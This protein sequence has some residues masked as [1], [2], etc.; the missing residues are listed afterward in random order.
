MVDFIGIG[1]QRTAT[2]WLYSCM[3]EH[4]EICAPEKEIHFFSRPRYEEKGVEWYKSIFASRCDAN[5]KKGEF[6][7]SYLYDERA[8][9]RIHKDFPDVKILV[10][11]REPAERAFSQYSL[12]AKIGKIDPEKISFEEFL[13]IEPSAKEQGFYG[14]Q[15]ARYYE[16][17]PSEHIHVMVKEEIDADGGER[18]VLRELFTF[19]G[20]DPDFEPT[21]ID[22]EIN[23]GRVSKHIWVGK[24]IQAV[25]HFLYT[26][27]MDKLV[28]A[29]K[30]TGLPA[31]LRQERTAKRLDAMRPETRA[32]LRELYRKDVIKTA[33]ITGIDVVSVWG[34]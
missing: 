12:H 4:P 29:V 31:L 5:K 18:K 1:A 26:H 20:V 33:E 9:A 25:S 16:L 21:L 15:L 8:A 14:E 30:K 10:S 11:L 7:T 2:S 13:K 24:S 3:Y 28:F 23:A 6:S 17:F 27:G 34:Y 19:L 22:Q 32:E